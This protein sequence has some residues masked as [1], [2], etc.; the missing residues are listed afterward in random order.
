MVRVS[1][2]DCYV[3]LDTTNGD[4]SGPFDP[5]SLLDTRAG[6]FRFTQMPIRPAPL[7]GTSTNPDAQQTGLRRA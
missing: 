4:L 6:Y 2:L 7:C 1:L 5:S 3:L